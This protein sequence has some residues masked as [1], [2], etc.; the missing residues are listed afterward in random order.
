MNEYKHMF[1]GFDT[2]ESRN[3]NLYSILN[4]DLFGLTRYQ[5]N[6]L[7]LKS[8]LKTNIENPIFRLEV[9]LSR[10]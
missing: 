5:W 8:H 9:F 10:K 2:Y 6:H 4:L 7:I 1:Q 3:V